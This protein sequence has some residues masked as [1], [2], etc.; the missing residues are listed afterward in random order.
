M[1][2]LEVAVPK[3]FH[4]ER[5]YVFKFI[6][7]EILGIQYVFKESENNNYVIQFDGK[8][9]I[10]HDAFFPQ[11]KSQGGYC[12][13]LLPNVRYV[14]NFFTVEADIPVL[15]GNENV[16]STPD[17]ID[18]EID[19][20]SSI[21]F[22]LTRWEE[23][24]YGN[25]A[26]DIHSRFIGSRSIAFRN[27]FLKRPIVNEYIEMLWNMMLSLGF[28]A[29]R[30][31][32]RF[33][34]IPTHDI[35]RLLASKPLFRNIK[36][37][38]LSVLK[39][40]IRSALYILTHLFTN[41][42]DLFGFFM[43]CSEKAG[44]KSHF[45]FMSSTFSTDNSQEPG[46]LS[47]SRFKGIV[48]NINDRGHFVGIHPSYFSYKNPERWTKEKQLLEDAIEQPI[49][50][51]RQHYLRLLLPETLS[52]WESNKM[53][54]DSSLSYADV[55]GFRCG[56]GDLFHYFDFNNHSEYNL[57]ERPL[58]VMEGTLLD[59]RK[60]SYKEAELVLND[61]K[62]ICKK[63]K[64]PFTILFHNTSFIGAGTIKMRKLYRNLLLS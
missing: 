46:Y 59:Y 4:E 19:I 43:D 45:Y 18:C 16:S 62:G 5:E 3:G 23:R 14:K 38:I 61:Y 32:R 27:N 26:Y 2:N 53:K 50:E 34:I 49:S 47:D 56:T 63:Y 24:V 11:L 55:D 58:V 12:L 42:F 39:G 44:I 9:I 48:K 51:G 54:I 60:M 28:N 64:M 15:Y 37:S 41:P 10:I 29:C 7:S 8:S 30:K 25:D 57:L 17:C 21:Y 1:N 36:Y 22:M 31:E 33:E 52:I 40:E 35:D 13:S 20:I 6:F